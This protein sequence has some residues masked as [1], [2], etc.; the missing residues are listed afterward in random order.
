MGKREKSVSQMH[1]A[2]LD[3]S[4]CLTCGLLRELI[5]KMDKE[6]CRKQFSPYLDRLVR[7][8]TKYGG[9]EEPA[10]INLSSAGHERTRSGRREG[11][12]RVTCFASE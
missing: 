1:R 12:E 9:C 11:G 10:C 8:D 2:H 7:G 6:L 4:C 5:S 3:S